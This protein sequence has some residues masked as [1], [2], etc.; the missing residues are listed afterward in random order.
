MIMKS[1]LLCAALALSAPTSVFASD[2]TIQ[3]APP[4]PRP[5][6]N[7]LVLGSGGKIVGPLTVYGPNGE[8]VFELQDGATIENPRGVTGTWNN[9]CS[10]ITTPYSGSMP[11]YSGPMPN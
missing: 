1:A 7:V 6:I 4:T 9:C 5:P 10:V 2:I 3:G 8:K 11:A